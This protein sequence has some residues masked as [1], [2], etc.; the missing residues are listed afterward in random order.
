[1]IQSYF[2]NKKNLD[3]LQNITS[4]F[5]FI[6]SD[7]A[8]ELFLS[9]QNED[10]NDENPTEETLKMLETLANIASFV[11]AFAT[12][13]TILPNYV[14]LAFTNV[15]NKLT[16]EKLFELSDKMFDNSF[17]D[18]T[19]FNLKVNNATF[20]KDWNSKEDEIWDTL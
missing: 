3:F 2:S 20:A 6:Q 5:A 19:P 14:I 9:L 18:D 15:K 12:I 7:E 1:M 4:L 13:S 17:E 8:K 10:F 11:L 16:E